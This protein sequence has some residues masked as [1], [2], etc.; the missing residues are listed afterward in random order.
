M[1][2]QE[3]EAG[4]GSHW[5]KYSWFWVAEWT[6]FQWRRFKLRRQWG[7][8]A[9]LL[10]FSL[11][12]VWFQMLVH[13]VQPHWQ[14]LCWWGSWCG[15]CTIW[16]TVI[17]INRRC[18]WLMERGFWDWETWAAMEWASPWASW[19][20]TQPVGVCLHSSAYPSCWTWAQTMR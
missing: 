16:L 1:E 17:L 9:A 3:S 6:W 13:L 4:P 18:V 15:R 14:M 7:G 20:S 5:G 2:S 19:L 8:T 11:N 10:I 12:C